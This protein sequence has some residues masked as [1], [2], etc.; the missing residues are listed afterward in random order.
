[1]TPTPEELHALAGK[2]RAVTCDP[3]GTVCI[4]GSDADRDEIQSVLSGLERLA[5]QQES[6]EPAGT[7]HDDGYFTWSKA[8]PPEH[9][10]R[11]NYAGWRLDFYLRPD[12]KVAELEAKVRELEQARSRTADHVLHLHGTADKLNARIIELE[13][14]QVPEGWVAVPKEPTEGMVTAVLATMPTDYYRKTYSM[15]L[16][17]HDYKVMLAA[18]AA[19]KKGEKE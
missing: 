15:E 13:A 7:L 2:L 11:S 19:E 4:Q 8:V 6:A 16:L 5:A 10:Y 14:R 17:K 3:D 1:M 12:P 18:L 9:K